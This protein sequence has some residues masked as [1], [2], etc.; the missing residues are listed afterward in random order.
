[1]NANSA[2][3]A[4]SLAR[5]GCAHEAD[6]SR[7]RGGASAHRE[8]E[9]R[10]LEHQSA[11]RAVVCIGLR[12]LGQERLARPPDRTD[13][14]LTHGQWAGD[15][16][17]RSAREAGA[18]LHGRSSPGRRA[19][20]G[21]RVVAKRVAMVLDVGARPGVFAQVATGMDSKPPTTL[22]G[23]SACRAMLANNR[24]RPPLL[25]G[26]G[27]LNLGVSPQPPPLPSPWPPPP[28]PPSPSL[29]HHRE[30]KRRYR[31]CLP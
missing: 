10:R 20:S 3:G 8:G 5:P 6:S 28:S 18:S 11:R 27:A 31:P 4:K 30:V 17:G 9:G 16:V 29:W 23:G 14:Q 24:R 26:R 25:P 7:S 15:R 12:C 19:E 1:M 22:R 21:T 13:R 2:A